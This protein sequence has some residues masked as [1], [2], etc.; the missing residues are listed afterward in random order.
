MN[1]RKDPIR[2]SREEVQHI[3]LL[4]RLGLS[5]E[6]IEKFRE[7]LSQILEQFQVLQGV[8]TAAV[9]PTSHSVPLQNIMRDDAAAPSP[10]QQDI[11]AN[12]PQSEEGFFRVKAVLEF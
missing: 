10:S 9:L 8:D 11:L 6:E 2:L 12:A 1:D 3:A 5:P 4:A 7:Q